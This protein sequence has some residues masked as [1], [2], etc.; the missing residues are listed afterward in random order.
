MPDRGHS[1][2]VPVESHEL[3]DRSTSSTSHHPRR[4]EPIRRPP[5]LTPWEIGTIARRLRYASNSMGV[6]V[7]RSFAERMATE[8]L[9]RSDEVGMVKA[10]GT[11]IFFVESP[12]GRSVTVLGWADPR[13]CL[14][15][16]ESFRL[17]PNPATPGPCDP[18]LTDGRGPEL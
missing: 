15:R 11:V 13:S 4:S 3:A 2:G 1:A 17:V 9:W 8:G 10:A 18:V 7:T 6:Q 12:D 14:D 5:V 16:F